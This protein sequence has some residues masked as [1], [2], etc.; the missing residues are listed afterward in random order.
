V[1]PQ[2]LARHQRGRAGE[3]G[4]VLKRLTATYQPGRRSADWVKV[5]KAGA[6]VCTVVG[7]EA[8]LCGPY[9]CV[10]LTEDGCD[11]A[12]FPVKSQNNLVIAEFA[13]TPDAFLGRKLV[14][15]FTERFPQTQVM[16]HPS[17]D[18]WASPEEVGGQVA[19]GWCYV[20]K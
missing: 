9:S 6:A 2:Q 1:L 3:E 14:V 7:F 12:A 19:V 5:K 15:S 20:G 13:A 16:R 8:G 17:F 10:T 11:R 18:H 4:A